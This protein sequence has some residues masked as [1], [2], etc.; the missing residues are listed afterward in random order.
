[1]YC[2][3]IG[4]NDLNLVMSEIQK[5]EIAEIRLDLC[6]FNRKQIKELFNFHHNLIA[7][8]RRTDFV[9]GKT[10]KQQ[11]KTAIKAGAQ[12]VDIDHIKD[13][14][15]FKKEITDFAQEHNTKVIVS[16]HDYEKTPDNEYIQ[17]LI[18]DIKKIKPDLIKLAFFAQRPE[19]NDRVLALYKD[20]SHILAFNMGEVGKMSRVGCVQLGAPFTYV[21]SENCQTAPGQM[22]KE[23]MTQY[24]Q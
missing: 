4:N 17:K 10:R 19:D 1:M 20:N 5:Y 7:T 3:S 24:S 22:T 14:N 2:L 16:I 15:S 23:E 21:R 18:V 9:S 11:L 6:N 8:F 12:W 13:S